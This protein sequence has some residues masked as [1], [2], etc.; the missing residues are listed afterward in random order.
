MIKALSLCNQR[1]RALKIYSAGRTRTYN[2]PVTLEPLFSQRGGLS[3]QLTNEL[4]GAC[5]V[6]LVAAPQPLV[7]A[8][9]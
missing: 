1:L 4:P 5:G 6:L 3:H 7:S 2:P 8:R 9:S